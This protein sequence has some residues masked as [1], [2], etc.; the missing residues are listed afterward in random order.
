MWDFPWVSFS[1]ASPVGL[2][3]PFSAHIILAVLWLGF[4]VLWPFRRP[5]RTVGQPALHSCLSPFPIGKYFRPFRGSFRPNYSED[6]LQQTNQSP[7]RFTCETLCQSRRQPQSLLSES[8][9]G[10]WAFWS[11]RK[12]CILFRSFR[13]L[14]SRGDSPHPS[15][16]GRHRTLDCGTERQLFY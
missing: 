9:S 11:G 16:G 13:A 15:S 7:F 10:C 6:I 5:L 1:A 12:C 14:R 4:A 2:V 8:Q 3:R